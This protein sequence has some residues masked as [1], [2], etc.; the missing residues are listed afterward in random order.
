[1]TMPSLIWGSP[2]WMAGGARAP[3]CRDRRAPLELRPRA[4]SKR[5]VRIGAA[6]LKG[7]GLHGSGAQLARAAP[8]RLAAAAR[9]QRFCDPGRQQPELADPR[10]QH[11]PHPR[12]MGA[13]PARA[14]SRPG[15]RGWGKITTS[16]ATCSTP[17]SAPSMGST[18]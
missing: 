8:D 11:H 13:R 3:G 7:A 10:R 12:R 18:P 2:H 4:E 15:R 14:R 5:S 1:M 16:A 17:T 9:G 6:V